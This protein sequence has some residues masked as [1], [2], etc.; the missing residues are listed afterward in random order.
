MDKKGIQIWLKIWTLLKIKFDLKCQFLLF[1]RDQSDKIRIAQGK[2]WTEVSKISFC[3]SLG[4]SSFLLTLE[5]KKS[6]P[7]FLQVFRGEKYLALS[8][9]LANM[10]FKWVSSVWDSGVWSHLPRKISS[11]FFPLKRSK[12]TKKLRKTFFFWR[13]NDGGFFKV[14]YKV[15]SPWLFLLCI[16]LLRRF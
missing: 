3:S 1:Q 13:R 9:P 7:S 12:F 2:L 5:G 11:T 6:C 16:S 8:N 15:P 14:F 4:S 10:K